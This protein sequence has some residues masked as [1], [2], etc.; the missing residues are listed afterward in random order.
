MWKELTVE[1]DGGAVIGAITLIAVLYRV[2]AWRMSIPSRSFMQH[3]SRYTTRMVCDATQYL[4]FATD[5]DGTRERSSV[6]W[7]GLVGR[8]L[9]AGGAKP[10][11][12][13]PRH[14]DEELA[15]LVDTCRRTEFV[16]CGW[17]EDTRRLERG[18]SRETEIH[19]THRD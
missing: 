14:F 9:Q 1:L 5:T 7:N 11:P 6:G 3:A 15:F 17:R 2:I 18:G 16:Q 4:L 19:Y 10:I 8:H 12:S 13:P